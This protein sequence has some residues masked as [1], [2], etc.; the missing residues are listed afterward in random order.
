MPK[1]KYLRKK[2]K[3]KRHYKKKYKKKMRKKPILN[4]PKQLIPRRAFVV[5]KFVK[6]IRIPTRFESSTTPPTPVGANWLL[7][8]WGTQPPGVD[9]PFNT[10]IISCNSPMSPCNEQQTRSSIFPNAPRPE[11]KAFLN[12]FIGPGIPSPESQALFDTNPRRGGS[13]P[14]TEDF[15]GYYNEYPSFWQKM[16][17]WYNN[18]TVI[19][20]KC[21][22]KFSPDQVIPVGERN[23]QHCVFTMGVKKDRDMADI[24]AEPQYMQEA[25]GY[26]SRE[27]VGTR[28][29]FGGKP[30]VFSMTRKWS[31]KKNM[32]LS[33]GDI[34]GN[35]AIS[36]NFAS[37]PVPYLTGERTMNTSPRL[38]TDG[39][40]ENW[41]TFPRHQN[42]FT[43]S[44][45]SLLTNNTIGAYEAAKY[46]SG[47]L[48]I[49]LSYSTIWTDGRLTNNEFE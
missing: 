2:R 16:C 12:A 38:P 37:A 48:K 36:G 3:Y 4:I 34:V 9:I 24:N 35:A 26:I 20:S 28:T 39:V 29:E 27:Y 7:P 46:P 19:G 43:F 10:L 1:K 22:I 31:A 13:V 18:Y 44:C 8:Y 23:L 5:H 30:Y 42:Y 45:N 40:D 32:G 11:T 49:E 21:N 14:P 41:A 47:L 17:S 6:Y 15:T 25:P 33:K